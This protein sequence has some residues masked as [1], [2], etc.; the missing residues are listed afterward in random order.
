MNE[1]RSRVKIDRY[2]SVEAS[3]L[4]RFEREGKR[5]GEK[6][7][8]ASNASDL[9]RIEIDEINSA[10][11]LWSSFESEIAAAK[12]KAE[13]EVNT[14]NQQIS[15]ALPSKEVDAEETCDAELGKIETEI[16]PGS[17]AF[18][19]NQEQLDQVATDL[20]NVK[21]SLNNRELQSQFESFYVP[22]MFALA[23][24]EVWVNSKS[25]EL[26]FASNQ[27]ISL[28]LASAVGAMLV[29]FAHITGSSIKRA[30]PDEAKRGR[31]KTTFSMV[32]LNSLVAVFILFLGKMRQAWVA[33]DLEDEAGLQLD[34]GLDDPIEGLE[35]IVGEIS[36]I[37]SLIGT[38]LGNE[39]LFLLLFNV[40]VYV[41]GTVAAILRHDSHPD[42][43]SLVRREQK[44]RDKQVDMKKRYQTSVAAAEKKKADTLVQVR[45]EAVARDGELS[46]LKNYIEGLD[47]DL[48]TSK[49]AINKTLQN[50]IKAFRRGNRSTRT[51]KAPSYFS[52]FPSVE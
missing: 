32:M 45:K 12:S 43:E 40:L 35:N 36:G 48:S 50:K 2:I 30:L 38:E 22:F 7:L 47:S 16:G 29:F 20:K 34:L 5:L 37:Q 1:I 28:L 8:P 23:F 49:L 25:F 10:S 15:V 26:F 52:S 13:T 17:A 42:Y 4:D 9:S 46:G 19:N 41:A 51:S 33:L 6:D 31:A 24:A 21:S 44:H 27:L 39:G 14:I 11:Q 3:A 18:S